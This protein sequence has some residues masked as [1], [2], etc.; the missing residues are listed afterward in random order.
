MINRQLHAF[1]CNLGI[2]ALRLPI[3]IIVIGYTSR[4]YKFCAL[5]RRVHILLPLRPPHVPRGHVCP[6]FFPVHPPSP[7]PLREISAY[8]P[9]YT[10]SAPSALSE[11]AKQDRGA[12]VFCHFTCALV[13]TLC[14]RLLEWP[15]SYTCQKC[16][17]LLTQ[18]AT[19]HAASADTGVRSSCGMEACSD[20]QRGNYNCAIKPVW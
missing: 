4:W 12:G 9:V 11:S 3:L 20:V 6:L 5:H 18:W 10:C 15:L 17:P 1:S 14:S 8:I 2:I 13:Q 7:P 19:R 16:L